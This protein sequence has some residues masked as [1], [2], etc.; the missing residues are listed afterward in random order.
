MTVVAETVEDL[1]RRP[2]ALFLTGDQIYADDID[3][4]VARAMERIARRL[5]PFETLPRPYASR[6]E[7]IKGGLTSSHSENHALLFG[8]YAALYLLA[9]NGD[10]RGL[11]AGDAYDASALA[12]AIARAEPLDC[13]VV[14]QRRR[15]LR[16]DVLW[17]Y[18][19]AASAR[20]L[21]R[22]QGRTT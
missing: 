22:A 20:L 10:H 2:A 14:R 4:P 16:D 11:G 19:G 1:A 17:T 21:R 13:R 7:A 5:Q 12:G 15:L 3:R 8:E 6:K 18:G 9:W